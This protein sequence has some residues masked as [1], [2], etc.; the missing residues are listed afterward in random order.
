MKLFSSHNFLRYI[1]VVPLCLGGFLSSVCSQTQKDSV[2]APSS[3]DR[4]STEQLL[5]Q[6]E[7]ET[8]NSE[9]ID[10]LNWLQEHPF[11]LNTVSREELATL[12][13]LTPAE[14]AAIITFRKQLKRFNFVQQISLIET[15]G[16]EILRKIQPYVFAENISRSSQS[17]SGIRFTSRAV[18][19]VQPRKGFQDSSF[20]GSPLKSYSRLT[21]DLTRELEAGAL[22]E[23]DAGEK[24]GDGFTSAYLAV[25]DLLFISQAVIGDYVV[26]AGQGLVFW[27]ATA[28]GKGS[29]A[30]SVVKKPST[31][32]QPYRSSDEFNFLRGVSVSSTIVVGENTLALT[33]LFSRHALNAS[34]TEEFVTSFYEEG[35][36]R[37]PNELLK[38][39]NIIEKLVGGRVK[40]SSVNEWNIGGTFYHSTFNKPVVADRLFEFSG[41][42]ATVA[43]V[44]AEMNLGWLTPK[45][46]QITLFG[47][48]ARSGDGAGAGIVGSILNLTRK[49]SLALM[50]RNYSPRFTSLHATGFGERSDTKNESGF[51]IGA[52]VQAS[53][54][55]HLSG[56]LDHFKFPWRTFDNP[57][58]TSGR[59]VL[60]QADVSATRSLD[61]SLRYTDKKTETTEASADHLLR[62]TRIL[63]DRSQQKFRLT[64][65]YQANK[66]LR[67]RGR[68]EKTLVDYK[69]LNRSEHGLLF[70]QELHYAWF[71][72][73]IAEARLIFFDTDSYDSRLYEY[74]NDLRGI[75]SNPALSGK[76][77]RWYMLVRWKVADI[78]NLS[79]KYSETQYDDRNIIG[80][81][82]TEIQGDVDNRI[83]VQLDVK[84]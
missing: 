22:F 40:L 54:W 47:E 23:K 41:A 81:G 15:N 78:L 16:E 37:T 2:I 32:V 77:R 5:D 59:D 61:L 71:P 69:L 76:G 20:V 67:L 50:Y 25:K 57:L 73:L 14:V 38:K 8:D 26:E 7:T 66:Q 58:P 84:F 3:D 72:N 48:A 34:G 83:S 70:Y 79:A 80:S 6:V 44:D 42:S 75:F 33:G 31:G 82:L 21:F 53:K 19:D 17:S 35:L 51:Y 30:V 1:L 9:I 60:L 36:F 13:R 56:Y 46:F 55:L 27:R 29:E 43:G 39:S 63:V 62:E 4:Q 24:F 28:F 68:I 45:L 64:A 11:D 12:P 74:E 52:D 10:R 18:R 65:T 49:A